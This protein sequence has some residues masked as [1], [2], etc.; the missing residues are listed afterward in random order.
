[1]PSLPGVS[2]RDVVVDG[3]RLHVA[4]AGHGP[5][6]VLLHGW[7]QHWWTWR[8]VLP[9]LARDHHVVCPDLRGLGWS[10]AP[11]GG[12]E[13]QRLADDLIGVL[14]ALGLDRVQ[15]VGHDWGGFAAF[16]AAL[17]APQRF[18]G[19]LALSILHPWPRT[20]RPDPRRLARLYYQAVVASP[21]GEHLL[22]YE[23]LTRRLLDRAADGAWDAEALDLYA[24]VLSQPAAARASVML[25]RTFLLRELGPL[26]RGAYF[27]QR[28]EVP[29][30][31]LVGDR[32][33]VITADAVA[34]LSEHADPGTV[35]WE[36]GAG[37]WLPEERPERVLTELA[38]LP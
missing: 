17:K 25:Y 31:M 38:L 2:H 9:T 30:R 5:A 11:P 37:H 1:M 15:L 20:G 13:K 4:E 33:P 24:E 10:Q 32:D 36:A 23:G 12:Y 27:G 22:R 19:L 21:V 29:T 6:V 3:V 18:S 34:G 7:P 28:L 14:D 35:T 26:L 16:L 8:R